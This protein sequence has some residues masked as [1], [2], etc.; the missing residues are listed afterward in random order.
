V[1]A[2]LGGAFQRSRVESEFQRVVLLVSKIENLWPLRDRRKQRK[3]VGNRTVVKVRRRSP[4]AIMWPRLVCQ[5][6]K[7]FVCPVAIPLFLLLRRKRELGIRLI[8]HLLRNVLQPI[9]RGHDSLAQR[10]TIGGPVIKVL[11]L[12]RIGPDFRQWNHSYFEELSA[13][14]IRVVRPMLGLATVVGKHGWLVAVQ[15]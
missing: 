12:F 1:S 4:D 10:S 13:F 2:E 11:R 14:T 8:D 7:Q 6:G 15:A 3:Q 9:A 5:R